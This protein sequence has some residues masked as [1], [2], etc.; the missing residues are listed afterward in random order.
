MIFK[1]NK[2]KIS[3]LELDKDGIKIYKVSRRIPEM[4][5][6]E[7]KIFKTKEEAKNKIKEWLE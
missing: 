1:K 5:I 7:T 6:S 2:W 4:S 3:I